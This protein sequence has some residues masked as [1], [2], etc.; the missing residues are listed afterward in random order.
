MSDQEQIQIR[1]LTFNEL[2]K[3]FLLQCS[4]EE[5]L[6]DYGEWDHFFQKLQRQ[7]EDFKDLKFLEFSWWY[8]TWLVCHQLEDCIWDLRISGCAY[9]TEERIAIEEG[10]KKLWKE[11]FKKLPSEQKEFLENLFEEYKEF[12]KKRK[13]RRNE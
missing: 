3:F 7:N 11:E 12:C 4:E 9:T 10:V 2:V 5:G 13:E 1:G 8:D 6:C